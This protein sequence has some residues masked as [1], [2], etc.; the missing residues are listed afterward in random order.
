MLFLQMLPDVQQLVA[1]QMDQP[2]ALFAFAVKMEGA[3]F[4][5]FFGCRFRRLFALDR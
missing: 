2:T 4:R 5:F 3:A 1:V